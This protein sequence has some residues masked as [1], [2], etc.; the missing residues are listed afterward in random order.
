VDK[1]DLKIAGWMGMFAMVGMLAALALA[2]FIPPPAAYLDQDQIAAFYQER[3]TLIKIGMIIGLAASMGYLT[4]SAGVS[5]QMQKMK[6]VGLI[7]SY[8]QLI[9]G[10]GSTMML[11]IPFVFMAITAYRADT[12]SHELTLML[13]DASWLLFLTPFTTFIA[14]NCAIGY[15][16]L[17]DKSE[18]PVFPRWVG[19]YNLWVAV[20]FTP[21][22]IA[23]LFKSGPFAWHSIFPF[24]I[25]APIFLFWIGL[26]SWMLIR[27][28]KDCDALPQA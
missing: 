28:A 9:S 25:P 21:V 12:R 18:Q 16:V 7:P 2:G 6:G 19:Y 23:Y 26:M 15:A 11:V 24:W 13:N 8:L 27:G 22:G 14:Q 17:R 3:G 10:A 1:T 20:L 5:V 4:I